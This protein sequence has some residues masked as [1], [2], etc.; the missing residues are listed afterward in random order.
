[1]KFVLEFTE[2]ERAEAHLAFHAQDL[3]MIL[4]EFDNWLRSETKHNAGGYTNDGLQS[5]QKVRD[6]LWNELAEYG[7]DL[8]RE[9]G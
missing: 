4:S 9:G 7:I 8:H 3:F 5:L 6:K 1:M 2:E